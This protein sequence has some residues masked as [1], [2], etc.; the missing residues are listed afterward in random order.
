MAH[1][2]SVSLP[3]RWHREEKQLEVGWELIDLGANP[4]LP[5]SSV[6]EFELNLSFLFCPHSPSSGV[7]TSSGPDA[8][9]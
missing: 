5:F 7:G 1:V 8:Q 2:I 6:Y 4:N 9:V 3:F